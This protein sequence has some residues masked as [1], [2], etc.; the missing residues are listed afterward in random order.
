MPGYLGPD[1][2]VTGFSLKSSRLPDTASSPLLLRRLE[3]CLLSS[4]EAVLVKD[5][6]PPPRHSVIAYLVVQKLQTKL[7][8]PPMETFHLFA[9]TTPHCLGFPPP[10]LAAHSVSHHWPLSFYILLSKLGSP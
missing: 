4:T 5:T 1:S 2:A 3:L 9:P 6:R 7:A 8:T 10:E